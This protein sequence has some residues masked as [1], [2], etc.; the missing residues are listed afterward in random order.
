VRDPTL[1]LEAV[2][3]VI[4]SEAQNGLLFRAECPSPITGKEGNRE[5]FVLFDKK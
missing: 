1:H 4:N 5:F 3:Q 2:R